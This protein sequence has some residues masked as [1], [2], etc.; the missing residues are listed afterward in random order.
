L[1]DQ[2][3]SGQAAPQPWSVEQQDKTDNYLVFRVM[4]SFTTLP[5]SSIEPALALGSRNR[6]ES[7]WERSMGV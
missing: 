3:K 5:V 7:R 2:S 1:P 4:Q 6:C